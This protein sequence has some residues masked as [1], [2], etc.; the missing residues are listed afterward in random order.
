VALKN[1]L[2]LDDALD[3]WG[4][5]GVG[6]FIGVILLGIFAS[7]A[8]N[9]GGGVDGLLAG[10]S[11]FFWKQVVAVLVSSV[12]AFGFTYG[13]LW[14]INVITPVRVEDTNEE[15]GLDESLHGEHAYEDEDELYVAK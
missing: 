7:V 6:G 14:L 5:H 15:V 13:M 9:P 4:V 11:S 1:K 2:A 8:F 12:W 3:V 10:N